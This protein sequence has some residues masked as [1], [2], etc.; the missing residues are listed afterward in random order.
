MVFKEALTGDDKDAIEAKTQKLSEA[1]S[2]LAER[3]YAQ[4]GAEGGA[5][6]GDAGASSSAADDDI[7]DAEFEE[8]KDEKK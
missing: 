4:K 2:K 7:V 6:A 3:L 8:V 1:S 5:A